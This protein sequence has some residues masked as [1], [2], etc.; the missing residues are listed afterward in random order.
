MHYPVPVNR[1][2]DHVTIPLRVGAGRTEAKN[3]TRRLGLEKLRV[4][5]GVRGG[6]SVS[7]VDPFSPIQNNFPRIR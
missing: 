7:H 6:L 5:R 3:P 4:M 1:Y 2:L